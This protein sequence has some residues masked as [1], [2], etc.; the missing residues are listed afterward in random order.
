MEGNR[1]AAQTY[2]NK[3][4]HPLDQGTFAV[5]SKS[6]LNEFLDDWLDNAAKQRLSELTYGDYKYALDRYVRPALGL[7]KLSSIQPLD[8]QE[9]YTNMREQGLSPRTVQITHNIL[10]SALKQAVKWRVLQHNPAQFVD[11]PKQVRKEMAALS[12]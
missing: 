1:K 3:V 7:K 12:P 2:L 9:L 8:I 5:S 11:R 4:L 6:T 10:S